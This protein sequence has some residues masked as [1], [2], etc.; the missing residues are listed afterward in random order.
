MDQVERRDC[1]YP[2]Q[3][4]YLSLRFGIRG[5][6]LHAIPIR[7]CRLHAYERFLLL[8]HQRCCRRISNILCGQGRWYDQ[9]PR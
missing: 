5:C 4:S 7:Q 2:A 3:H 9:G 6:A 1:R 8:G